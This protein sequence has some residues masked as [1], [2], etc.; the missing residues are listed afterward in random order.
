[1]ITL[2]IS[3]FTSIILFATL[4]GTILGIFA[5]FHKLYR[6]L[7]V[8]WSETVWD[9]ITL[10]TSYRPYK[11]IVAGSY[12]Q[13][14]GWVQHYI[15]HAYHL[16]KLLGIPLEEVEFIKVGT[17]YCSPLVESGELERRIS[18]WEEFLSD[19]VY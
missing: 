6:Q 11:V 8:P 3:T 4:I 13:F 12:G 9:R 10:K 16:G 17:W 5:V 1:M 18:N 2:S 14:R 7:G 19:P 15:I